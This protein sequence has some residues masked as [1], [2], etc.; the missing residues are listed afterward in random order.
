MRRTAAN[1]RALDVS[2]SRVEPDTTQADAVPEP[3][4]GKR[5]TGEGLLRSSG[6]LAA[7]TVTSRVT[8]L[9][10]VMV[11]SWVLGATTSRLADA[12][13][14]ANTAPNQFYEL[15]LGGIL[16]SVLVPLFV[17]ALTGRERRDAW[18]AV[19]NLFWVALAAAAAA[20][21]M[22]ALVAPW[23]IGFATRGFTQEQTDLAVVLLRLFSAQV[24]FYAL[25]ALAGALLN[26]RRRF[27]V[28]AFV[29][30]LNNIVVIVVL[31]VFGA[32]LDGGPTTDLDSVMILLLGLG[33]TAG[34]AVMALA[35]IPAVRSM[36]HGEG[37]SLRMSLALR[38]PMIVRLLRLS[39]WTV[40]YVATNQV[41]LYIVQVLANGPGSSAGDYT[42][43]T[44]AFLFFQLPNGVFAVSVL[45]ALLPGLAE[46]LTLGDREG[47]KTRLAEGIRLTVFLILP[48]SVGYLLLAPATIRLFLQYRNFTPDAAALTAEVLQIFAI[49]LIPFTLFMLV[50]RS[51]YAMQDTRTPFLVNLVSTSVTVAFDIVVYPRLGIWGLAFGYALNYTV[52]ACLGWFLL[53]RR[54]GPMRGTGI[55]RS[56]LRCVVATVPLALVVGAVVWLMPESSSSVGALVEVLLGTSLGATAYLVTAKVLDVDEMRIVSR[57]LARRFG[58]RE[59]ATGDDADRDVSTME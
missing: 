29:P 21:S 56:V 26:S 53:G 31:V 1:G 57:I 45:T 55:D 18:R 36:V 40:L 43:W 37:G 41:G 24:F 6:I 16:T 20:A 51:F 27:A 3:A 28:P 2:G 30:A 9:V 15:A 17:E 4:G 12:Y 38:D 10:K 19:S 23:L 22:L 44:N 8:G 35:N 14:L 5:D 42:A 50:L 11:A 49:G 13:N 32:G 54:I 7:G 46:R 52:A 34:V 48:A 39:T 58:R 47:F 59:R 33:T 25:N